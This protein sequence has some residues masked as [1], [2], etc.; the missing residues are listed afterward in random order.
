MAL[1][2][3]SH[4]SDG[5]ASKKRKTISNQLVKLVLAKLYVSFSKL[6]IFTVAFDTDYRVKT[7][8]KTE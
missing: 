1:K 4:S 3:K 7:A 6:G 8:A 5:S 2:C